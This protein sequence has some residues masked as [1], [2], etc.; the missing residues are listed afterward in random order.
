MRLA[1]NDGYTRSFATEAEVIDPAT[2][3]ASASG[4]PVITGRYRPAHPDALQEW[5]WALGRATCG[6][7]EVT[8]TANHLAAHLTE[9]DVTISD[10]KTIAPLSADT[11]R[12]V[13]EPVL[14]Q[15]VKIVNTWAPKEKA[16][17]EG[18]SPTG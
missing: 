10:G 5:R 3:K 14:N 1:L 8:A 4:L 16:A 17:D 2:G 6:K 12:Q 9:W 11:I 15:L 7:D 18:N 13:P